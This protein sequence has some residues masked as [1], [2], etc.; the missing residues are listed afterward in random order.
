[1]LLSQEVS[2]G[3][4]VLAVTGPVSGGDVA[5]LRSALDRAVEAAPRGVVVDLSKA[6]PLAP[7]A[8]DVLN[9][10]T[11]HAA[12]WPRPALAV[13]C[14]GDGLEQLLLPGVQMHP[15]RDDA[16]A[17]VDDRSEEHVCVRATVTCGPE[18]PGEARRLAE[19][20]AKDNGF[21]GDDL[22]VVV[23][24]L[25]TNAVR[26]GTAPVEIEIGTCEHCVTVVVA[27]AGSGR[28]VQREAEETDEG[29]RGLLLVD[30]LAAD[31]GV[32]P[33]GAGKAVWAE[34]PRHA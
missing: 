6:G 29:G 23:T 10:A 33:V 1:M 25:V 4:E 18:G 3:V 26:H 9:W 2:E 21:D 19:Q 17:H 34:L 30:L 8:V 14:A 24:E 5:A 22:A 11:L 20:C 13:C 15:C 31:N 28:P 16:L 7:A 32:R 12:G 27:D